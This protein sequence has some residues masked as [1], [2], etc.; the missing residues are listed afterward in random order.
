L[1]QRFLS[2]RAGATQSSLAPSRREAARVADLFW[3]MTDGM[4]NESH[5]SAASLPTAS[6]APPRAT[7]TSTDPVRSLMDVERAA[8]GAAIRAAQG[9]ISG[10]RGAATLLGL[11]PTTLHAKMKKLGVRREDALVD[12]R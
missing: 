4:G 7:A 12:V 11:K 2:R 1:H 9:R 5:A 3:W 6:A 8:I 10:A